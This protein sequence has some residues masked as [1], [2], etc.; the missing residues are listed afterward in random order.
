MEKTESLFALSKEHYKILNQIEE[1]ESRLIDGDDT[2]VEAMENLLISE[3][4]ND[5]AILKK[6]NAFCWVINKIYCRYDARL[7]QSKRL[8]N[9]A[10]D[11]LAEINRLKNIVI[12]AVKTL[13]PSKANL[14]LADYEL[15][16]IKSTKVDITDKGLLDLSL[17][18]ETTSTRPDKK[19][20]KK[21][22]KA[23]ENVPGARLVEERNWLIT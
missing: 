2:A 18:I 3:E 8:Q 22:L 9:L 19:E 10:V 4:N 15:K 11:D 14:S 12:K 13:F 5:N 7:K 6:L 17:I 23:G 16:S 21:R 20:I 1:L